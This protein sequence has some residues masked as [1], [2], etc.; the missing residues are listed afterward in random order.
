MGEKTKS[1]PIAS[2]RI[3]VLLSL[4]IV[5]FLCLSAFIILIQFNLN[6]IIL[7]L[8]SMPFAFTY[9]LMKRFT[10]WPQLFLGITFNYGL[11]LGWTSIENEIS[12]GRRHKKKISR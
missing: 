6:T 9:P 7:G 2:G 12:I 4:V 5:L 1:R 10:Y 3:S 8:A 11:I